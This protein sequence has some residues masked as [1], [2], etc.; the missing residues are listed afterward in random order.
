M[1]EH[2]WFRYLCTSVLLAAYGGFDLFSRLAAWSRRPR[3]TRRPL[4]SHLLGFVSVLLLYGVIGADG[5]AVWNGTGNRIGVIL[6]VLAMLLRFMAR[7]GAGSSRHPDLLA[8]LLFYGAIAMVVGSPRS[9]IVFAVPQ[10]VIAADGAARR[11]AREARD[12]AA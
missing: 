1:F 8:R 6:C 5:R 10:A 9:L 2:A 3:A 11:R 7:R 4:W 12:P